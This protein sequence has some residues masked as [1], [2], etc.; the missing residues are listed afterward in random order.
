MKLLYDCFQFVLA[1]LAFVIGENNQPGL[2]WT[3]LSEV[4]DWGNIFQTDLFEIRDFV[5]CRNVIAREYPENLSSL[6]CRI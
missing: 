1:R 2:C 6:Q 4:S 3:K 5:C